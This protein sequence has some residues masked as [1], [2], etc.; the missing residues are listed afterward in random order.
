MSLH[1]I[2]GFSI[3]THFVSS[4]N[5]TNPRFKVPFFRVSTFGSF[6]SS[7]SRTSAQ[8]QAHLKSMFSDRENATKATTGEFDSLA[9]LKRC[10]LWHVIITYPHLSNQTRILPIR[11]F[12]RRVIF[13]IQT[14]TAS[15]R[16][17][18]SKFY[19]PCQGFSSRICVNTQLPDERRVDEREMNFWR[20]V[21]ASYGRAMSEIGNILRSANTLRSG[22]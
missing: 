5:N 19:L 12:C 11:I 7:I 13:R 16:M 2:E 1:Q 9:C 21:I 8:L 18:M 22:Q 10:D 17:H 3:T 4:A 14:R 20:S 6:K 15:W